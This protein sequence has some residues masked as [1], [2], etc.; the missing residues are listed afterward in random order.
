MNQLMSVEI[1]RGTT[2]DGPGLRTTVFVKGCPL[3][4]IWCQNPESINPQQEIWYEAA[5]CI[6][7]LYCFDSC[8]HHALTTDNSGIEINRSQC[9]TCG[10]CMDNCPAKAITFAGTTWSVNDLVHEVMKDKHYY[11]EFGGGV[12]VSGGEP[13]LYTDFLIEFFIKLKMNNIHTALDTSGYF[14]RESLLKLIPH[15]DLILYDL[16]TFDSDEHIKFTGKSNELILENIVKIAEYISTKQIASKHSKGKD[17]TAKQIKGDD[18]ATEHST[19]MQLTGEDITTEHST[20]MQLTGEDITTEHI[21][22][23]HNVSTADTK[24]WIRTPLIPDATMN[25]NNIRELSLFIVEHIIQFVER[26]ELC[27]F[28]PIC[29]AK[30][31]KLQKPWPFTDKKSITQKQVNQ[32]KDIALSCGIPE[33]KLIVTGL[34]K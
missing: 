21:A 26:W 24:L 23:E 17:I 14:A 25:E 12:T 28:N 31:R 19:V 6:G 34:I 9:V 8:P 16:K 18:I 2:H 27:A 29:I 7:C 33:S 1:S 10:I 13:L 11:D 5:K 20:A 32:I 30:Y 15:V 4:C 3:N 22:A